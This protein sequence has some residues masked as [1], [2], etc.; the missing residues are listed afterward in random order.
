MTNGNGTQ[1]TKKI[2]ISLTPEVYDA[3]SVLMMRTG[4][5]RSR[6][7]E[8]VLRN[9]EHIEMYINSSR[10]EMEHGDVSTARGH[11]NGLGEIG[12]QGRNEEEADA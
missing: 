10:Y 8:T 4:L 2:S 12:V 7:I 3:V 11:H 1:R 6:P 9:D 5:N